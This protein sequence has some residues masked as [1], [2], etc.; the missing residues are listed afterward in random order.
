[1]HDSVLFPNC[2]SFFLFISPF[3]ICLYI[4]K[5]TALLCV[6]LPYPP[7]E[8]N[9]NSKEVFQFFPEIGAETGGRRRIFPKK[10]W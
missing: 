1:M 10:L 9:W 8:P 5:L 2:D 4:P 6:L 7:A 3:I